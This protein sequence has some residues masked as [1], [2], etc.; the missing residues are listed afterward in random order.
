MRSFV[1]TLSL[2]VVTALSLPATAQPGRAVVTEGP[3]V[4]SAAETVELTATITAIDA[5]TRA[6]VLKGKDGHEVTITAGPDVRNFAQMK[7]GDLVKVRYVEALSL[8]LKKGSTAPVS[9]TESSGSDGAKAG[10]RPAA[11]MGRKITIVA[12]VVALDPARQVVTLRSPQRTVDL[13][14]RDPEQFRLVAIGDRVEATYTE[15]VAIAV[16]PA[17]K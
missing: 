2:A 15:A 12:E 1:A 16:E 5:T 10:V 17:A 9:R 14:V 3:G 4:I 13:R 11:S 8:E 6:V 7:L